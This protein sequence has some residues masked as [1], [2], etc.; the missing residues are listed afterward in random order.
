M[1]TAPLNVSYAFVH[2]HT[3]M[4]M[5]DVYAISAEAVCAQA[6]RAEFVLP[7]WTSFLGTGNWPCD[8]DLKGL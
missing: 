7:V 1:E 2:Y 6:R 5:K 3:E 4:P 8:K